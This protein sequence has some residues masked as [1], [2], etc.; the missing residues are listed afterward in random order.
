M[1]QQPVE[2]RA[3]P[4]AAARMHHQ[5]GRLVQHQQ[6]GILVHDIERNRLGLLS[7]VTWFRLQRERH[8]LPAPDLAL[9]IDR[10]VVEPHL[11]L[12]DPGGKAAARMLREHPRQGLIEAHSGAIGG[13]I[14]FPA[15]D[16]VIIL[17]L[18]NI[19]ACHHET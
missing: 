4:V 14:P 11:A 10:G 6:R 12:P 19:R 16:C 3:L 15:L 5:S 9:G 17:R 2:Q 8:A 7:H 13:N 18:P 1:M